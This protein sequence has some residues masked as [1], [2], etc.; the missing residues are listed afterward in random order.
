MNYRILLVEDNPGDALLI[1]T[2][3]ANMGYLTVVSTLA[4]AIEMARQERF[5]VALVDA[6]LPDAQGNTAVDKLA[7]LGM[8]SVILMTGR[9]DREL[10]QAAAYSGAQGYLVK[11]QFTAVQLERAIFSAIHQAEALRQY[12]VLLLEGPDGVL[13]LSADAKVLFANAA[14]AFAF[15]KKSSDELIGMQ[16]DIALDGPAIQEMSLGNHR[17]MEMHKAPVLQFG[18]HAY[19]IMLR[20]VTD[21]LRLMSELAMAKQKLEELSVTDPLTGVLNRR[22]ME[23]ELMQS[24]R[25]SSRT[26]GRIAAILIDCDNFKSINE[27]F[28]YRVGDA[29]LQLVTQTVLSTL[30]GGDHLSRIGGDEFLVILPGATV[31]EAFYVANKIRDAMMSKCLP[32]AHSE[33]KEAIT[34][35]LGV[36]AIPNSVSALNEAVALAESALIMS[37]RGGKN[38]ASVVGEELGGDIKEQT[39]VRQ[40]VMLGEGIR[41]VA[42]AIVDVDR[43]IV[44]YELLMR[45]PCPSQF[46]MPSDFFASARHCNILGVADLLCLRRC[47][48]ASLCL[49]PCARVHLNLFPMTVLET[50]FDELLKILAL[51][52]PFQL[53]I[54]FNEQEFSGN[55]RLLKSAVWSLKSAGVLIALDNV[56]F[57]SS[58]LETLLLLEPDIVKIDRSMID[59]VADNEGKHRILERMVACL[60]SL[61][62]DIIAEGVEREQDAKLL[63]SMG[64]AYAQGY[65]WGCPALVAVSKD[66]TP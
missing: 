26:N 57:G 3:L 28:G 51:P 39:D 24:V 27:R 12:K 60:S 11:G 61:N 59:G 4:Q 9:D 56:G 37:K 6:G 66:K 42:Q 8:F 18:Q 30:R 33:Q 20:D 48:E 17:V 14:A 32:I 7:K 40:C 54:E 31:A 44:G 5:D 49:P 23:A 29:T 38:Q 36:A 47:L 64:I 43:N 55:A 63:M 50:P 41:V 1:Q 10:G 21:R 2:F 65:L 22:G 52:R 62:M 19:L 25:A 35:S 16:L 53:V 13:L 15:D 46:E 34:V 58:S 45:G